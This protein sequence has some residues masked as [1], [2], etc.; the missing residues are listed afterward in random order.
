MRV[1][2]ACDLILKGRLSTMTVNEI[3]VQAGFQNL[4]NFNRQFKK[5]TQY[6]PATY[7]QAFKNS[8]SPALPFRQSAYP[9]PKSGEAS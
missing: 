3:A 6:T 1:S 4:S 2:Y 9:Y 8:E 7:A 5:I